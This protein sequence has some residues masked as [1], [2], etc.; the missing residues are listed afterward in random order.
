MSELHTVFTGKCSAVL[1]DKYTA[2]VSDTY[3]ASLVTTDVSFGLHLFSDQ[4]VAPELIA[5]RDLTFQ[6]VDSANI[7]DG[8]VVSTDGVQVSLRLLSLDLGEY[9][10][11]LGPGWDGNPSNMYLFRIPIKLWL[12]FAQDPVI[13]HKDQECDSALLISGTDYATNTDVFFPN[14]SWSFLQS[15]PN[16]PGGGN[17]QFV[18]VAEVD[19]WS[20]E[21]PFSNNTHMYD[22]GVVVRGSFQP[23]PFTVIAPQAGPSVLVTIHPHPVPVNVPTNVLV[24]AI[25]A[26]THR[27]VAG[28][29]VINGAVVGHANETFSYVFK[30]Q[31]QLKRVRV[32]DPA[33]GRTSI[34]TVTL[35]Q[36][37]IGVLKSP[38]SRISGWIGDF[39]R[40]G[41]FN[42][43]LG[44]QLEGHSLAIEVEFAGFR[45]NIVPANF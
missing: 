3:F 28:N 25:D 12:N 1:I 4:T 40:D 23:F 36:A 26:S 7:S 20:Y 16:D 29:V 24:S 45:T 5:W 38:V 17:V 13:G 8:K 14:T 2:A 37:P 22:F 33:T 10:V 11:G 30:Y 9:R 42:E 41:S 6:T 21:F 32:A 15:S 35:T 44:A 27:P 43:N 34:E 39:C 19:T 31:L 18:A